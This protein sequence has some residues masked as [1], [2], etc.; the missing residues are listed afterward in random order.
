MNQLLN[1]TR[2]KA[3]W[4]DRGGGAVRYAQ[5]QETTGFFINVTTVLHLSG[6]VR[7]HA[8]PFRG[9][10]N[11]RSTGHRRQDPSKGKTAA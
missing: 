7:D 6:L 5:Q 1:V 10:G 3:H 9:Q 11:H 8:G 4:Y 2:M